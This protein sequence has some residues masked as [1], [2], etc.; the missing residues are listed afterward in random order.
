[1]R[2]H[3][4]AA[5]ALEFSAQP[6]PEHNRSGDGHP[7]A[8]RMHHGGAGEI[9]EIHSQAWQEMARGTHGRKKAIGPPAPVTEDRIDKTRT[10]D[11]VKDVAYKPG[12]A[13]HRA[14]ADRGSAIREGEL[15]EIV[16]ED[17]N[18]G[19]AVYRGDIDILH[20]YQ[21]FT[22]IARQMPA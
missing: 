12:P 15:E 3:R 18:A 9:M 5:V 22:G 7:S 11:G 17:G 2:H 19:R 4:P 8:D 16:C 21:T 14:G 1:M 6:G 10:A 20:E 13:D